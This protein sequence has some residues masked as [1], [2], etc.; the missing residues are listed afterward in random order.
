[1]DAV[2]IVERVYGWKCVEVYQVEVEGSR[3]FKGKL[4]F[5]IAMLLIF[6]FACVDAGVDA[7]LCQV[8][9]WLH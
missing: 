6:L 7:G 2:G 5:A 4:Y 9:R 8:C 3:N 1:M